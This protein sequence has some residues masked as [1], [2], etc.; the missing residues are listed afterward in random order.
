ML[1]LSEDLSKRVVYNIINYSY[2]SSNDDEE[3]NII[4]PRH[5]KGLRLGT[6]ENTVIIEAT[7][8]IRQQPF[9]A[10]HRDNASHRKT[11]R[12]TSEL[13]FSK[14]QIDQPLVQRPSHAALAQSN[15]VFQPLSG[16]LY[17]F[18][19]PASHKV[20]NTLSIQ[21]HSIYRPIL[22]KNT[23]SNEKEQKQTSTTKN[24]N[25]QTLTSMIKPKPKM[26]FP[27][28][29]PKPRQSNTNSRK[30]YLFDMT[31]RS[32]LCSSDM[33]RNAYFLSKSD[34]NF[35]QRHSK[36]VEA[37][38]SISGEID[39][40]I[41]AYPSVFARRS[42]INHYN[43]SRNNSDSIQQKAAAAAAA[44]IRLERREESAAKLPLLLNIS[45]RKLTLQKKS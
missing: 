13:P 4:L 41:H 24:S 27:S 9:R 12:T 3:D 16:Y 17:H 37:S 23:I 6:P 30:N 11:F 35:K 39:K 43:H 10:F 26:N 19:G 44:R 22:K 29:K 18:H 14:V 5:H 2:I 8:T 28:I 15:R 20:R 36:C 25:H 34:E 42:R 31:T 45:K 40:L 7:A 32:D 21:A 1:E 38:N 33:L